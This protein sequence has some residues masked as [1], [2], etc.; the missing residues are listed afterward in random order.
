MVDYHNRIM[1]IQSDVEDQDYESRIIYKTGYR[2]ARHAAA[3]IALEAERVIEELKE[4]IDL[5]QESLC[6]EEEYS[7][8]LENI[9]KIS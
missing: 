7:N 1:N 8:Y 2:D 4:I 3:E 9:L 6:S 5:L